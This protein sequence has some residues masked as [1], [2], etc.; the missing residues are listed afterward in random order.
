VTAFV[1]PRLQ[2]ADY[3][4]LQLGDPIFQSLDGETLVYEGEAPVYPVFVNEAAYYE[5]AIAFS[6]TRR[7]TI[8][9]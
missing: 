3:Q 7:E 4:P 2:D 8:W 1:H 6:V 5:K 9:V